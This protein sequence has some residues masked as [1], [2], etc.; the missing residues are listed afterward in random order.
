MLKTSDLLLLLTEI[1][2]E[3]VD[4]KKY[5]NRTILSTTIDK[6]VIAFIN[7]H[8]C[9]DV[10]KFYEKIRKSYNSKKS[11]L[12]INIV[13]DEIIPQECLTTL[14]ALNLQILLFA[15]KA[16]N[17]E[18]FLSHSRAEEITRVLNHYYKTYDLIP[19]YK[20]IKLIK[21]DIL[22]FEEAAGRR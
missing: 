17:K 8:R 7:S 10:A 21:A 13:K 15:E 4:V 3:G 1:G 12:Y 11:K 20:M 16:E 14:A 9:L 5:I 18:M 19:C 6:E 22:T 2:E